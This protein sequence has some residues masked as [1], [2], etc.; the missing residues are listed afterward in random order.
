MYKNYLKEKNYSMVENMLLPLS[1]NYKRI[2]SLKTEM[3]NKYTNDIEYKNA[4]KMCSEGKIKFCVKELKLET[5]L[6][7][8]ILVYFHRVFI[9]FLT[10]PVVSK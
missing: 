5:G 7:V 8:I 4:D 2:L 1:L 3:I 10:T 6:I 9:T